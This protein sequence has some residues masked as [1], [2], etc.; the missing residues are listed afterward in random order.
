MQVVRRE[1]LARL[2]GTPQGLIVGRG[3]GALQATG[4]CCGGRRGLAVLLDEPVVV[5]VE[6]TL[7]PDHL[8]RAE[9]RLGGGPVQGCGRHAACRGRL[10]SGGGRRHLGTVSRGWVGSHSGVLL[11]LLLWLLLRLLE[12]V[13]GAC[14]W[15]ERGRYG[16]RLLLVSPARRRGSSTRSAP[17]H[18]DPGA[19]VEGGAVSVSRE[20]PDHRGPFRHRRIGPSIS[21]L[22][23]PLDLLLDLLFHLLLLP[24]DGCGGGLFCRRCR[25]L[26]LLPDWESLSQTGWRL[27]SLGRRRRG[28][29]QRG[30][31][32]LPLLGY[33]GVLH[34]VAVQAADDRSHVLLLV[35]FLLLLLVVV[36]IVVDVFFLV[37]VI[38]IAAAITRVLPDGIVVAVVDDAQLPHGLPAEGGLDGPVPGVWS[39]H[40]ALQTLHV[41]N[42]CGLK[43]REKKIIVFASVTDTQFVVQRTNLSRM[44]P[45]SLMLRCRC[46]SAA[47]WSTSSKKHLLLAAA[48]PEPSSAFSVSDSELS[49]VPEPPLAAVAAAAEGSPGPL[50]RVGSTM[51]RHS[52]VVTVVATAAAAAAAAAA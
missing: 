32:W 52:I 12:E 28:G 16:G 39:F 29:G 15:V 51:V 30:Q 17:R 25:P 27:L 37:I 44:I 19:V 6:Q 43:A 31:R 1:Q 40:F 49:L 7:L 24:R 18:Y 10:L 45:M 8:L 34:G 21:Y 26:L 11:L 47:S 46:C 42:F 2:A 5:P 4:G 50:L 33:L 9:R 48:A 22:S 23:A 35:L 14:K 41:H 13:A 20:P 38:V 36:N 3:A